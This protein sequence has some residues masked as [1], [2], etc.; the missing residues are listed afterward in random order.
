[1]CWVSTITD[2]SFVWILQHIDS[3]G[4][5]GYYTSAV[6]KS[7]SFPSSCRSRSRNFVAGKAVYGALIFFFLFGMTPSAIGLYTSIG[8]Q[9]RIA[10][11]QTISLVLFMM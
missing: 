5:R 9:R 2:R 3:E 10:I 1:M 8:V 4:V 7:V 11:L 6:G